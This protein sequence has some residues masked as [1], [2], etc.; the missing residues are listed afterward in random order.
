VAPGG[1][2]GSADIIDEHGETTTQRLAPGH[3]HVIVIALRL[4]RLSGAQRLFQPPADAIALDRA[5]DA[6]RHREPHSRAGDGLP[7]G[8]VASTGLQ[9]EGLDRYA[10]SARDTLKFSP[11]G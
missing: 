6:S 1:A 7:L 10:P 11:S 8:S 5:T 3:Q 4:K 9:G 2:E